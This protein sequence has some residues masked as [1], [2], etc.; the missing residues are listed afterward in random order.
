L[1]VEVN[2]DFIRGMVEKDNKFIRLLD[3]DNVFS[4]E[5]VISIKEAVDNHD[6]NIEKQLTAEK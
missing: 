2:T 4:V 6:E 3:V 1:G 5:E